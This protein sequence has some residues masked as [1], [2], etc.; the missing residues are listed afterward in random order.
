MP[1]DVFSVRIVWECSKHSPLW[2]LQTEH[3]GFANPMAAAL[4]AHGYTAPHPHLLKLKRGVLTVVLNTGASLR[5][6]GDGSVL[7]G[8][9]TADL[10]RSGGGDPRATPGLAG[11]QVTAWHVDL[12]PEDLI[13]A[14]CD[15]YVRFP[16]SPE[17]LSEIGLDGRWWPLAMGS[18][19]PM[20]TCPSCSMTIRPP[21]RWTRGW[22][23]RSSPRSGRR[24]PRSRSSRRP[25]PRRR[26]SFW[27][28]DSPSQDG[29]LYQRRSSWR[30]LRPTSRATRSSSLSARLAA[31]SRGATIQSRAS[32]M[33]WPA[34]S[35]PITS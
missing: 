16:G 33:T 18:V 6:G 20:G 5:L 11:I 27:P 35:R 9:A 31:F 32:Q 17:D 22:M 1:R 2:E 4:F 34:R 29:R 15:S 14:T 25:S 3:P 8:S 13:V 28:D 23:M 12:D 21:A 26:P 10:V 7:L 30:S 24:L 19:G